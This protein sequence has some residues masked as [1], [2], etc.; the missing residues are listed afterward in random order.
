FTGAHAGA[1]RAETDVLGELQLQVVKARFTEDYICVPIALD[2][3]ESQ[4]QR[5]PRGDGRSRPSEPRKTRLVLLN[6]RHPL[7]ERNLKS[8]GAQVV[9]TTVELEAETRQLIITAPNT[10]GE[11]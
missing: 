4:G 10:G 1:I 9:P 5:S 7:L 8:K 11:Q 6:A 2:D 3:T